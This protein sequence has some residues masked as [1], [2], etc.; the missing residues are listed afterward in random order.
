M[1]VVASHLLMMHNL[2]GRW[3]YK[4]DPP[5]WSVATEWQIYLLFPALL[6]VWRRRGIAAAVA[7]GFALGYAVAALATP[8]GNPALRQLCPWYAGLFAIGM[9]GAVASRGPRPA[10]AGPAPGG[11]L[12]AGLGLVALLCAAS[13]SAGIGN[14]YVVAADPLVGAATACLLVRWARRAAPGSGAP[15]PP[16]LRLLESR[17]AVALGSISYSLYLIHYP[18]LALADAALRSRAWGPGPAW[19]R[20]CWSPRRCASPPPPCSTRPSSGP[21][22]PLSRARGPRPGG[23]VASRRP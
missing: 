8:L 1:G 23:T 16:V 15:R 2:D 11:L 13:V 6:A 12:A 7:A 20:C 17:R 9:A 18:L 14:P 10:A 21:G 19:R 3:L 5:M 22:G 4:V